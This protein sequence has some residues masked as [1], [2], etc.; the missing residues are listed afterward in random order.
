MNELPLSFSAFEKP[1]YCPKLKL[2]VFFCG[3]LKANLSLMSRGRR[4]V[5]VP[6]MYSCSSHLPPVI[7]KLKAIHYSKPRCGLLHSN[8]C[9]CPVDGTSMGINES[10]VP[11]MTAESTRIWKCPQTIYN[12]DRKVLFYIR[13]QKLNSF[14]SSSYLKKF[15]ITE[16]TRQANL[17]S[18]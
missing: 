15:D 18:L 10:S 12:A 5:I 8:S 13:W 1:L 3:R 16:A 7:S 2:K 14:L 6:L 17:Q 11:R 9:T 4:S